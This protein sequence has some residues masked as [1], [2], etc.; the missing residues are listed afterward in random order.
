MLRLLLQLV[1][2]LIFALIAC[3]LYMYFFLNMS[4]SQAVSRILNTVTRTASS[5]QVDVPSHMTHTPGQA[6]D[7]RL[8]RVSE[9][10]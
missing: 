4:F 9:Q 8:K 10:L 6:R 1:G 3:I 2:C 7:A 5:V